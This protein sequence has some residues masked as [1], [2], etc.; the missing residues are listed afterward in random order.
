LAWFRAVHCRGGW[1]EGCG[2]NSQ[3]EIDDCQITYGK[4]A[5]PLGTPL[6]K[7]CFGAFRYGFERSG[8]NSVPHGIEWAATFGVADVNPWI[9]QFVRSSFIVVGILAVVLAM[10]ALV[11][12]ETATHAILAYAIPIAILVLLFVIRAA[13]RIG[14]EPTRLGT[15]S[16]WAA[17]SLLPMLVFGPKA[18][19]RYRILFLVWVSAAGLMFPFFGGIGNSVVLPHVIL[20]PDASPTMLPAASFG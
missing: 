14:V 6:G 12:G 13:G 7:M 16:I 11:A 3:Y 1:I 2:G 18:P 9:F 20:L 10:R 15:A 19:R 4:T 5:R 17:S 8:V